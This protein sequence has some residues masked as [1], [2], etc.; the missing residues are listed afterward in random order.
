VI[1][2]ADGK[3]VQVWVVVVAALASALVAGTA[4]YFL[5]SAPVADMSARFAVEQSRVTSLTAQADLLTKLAADGAAEA[6]AAWAKVPATPVPDPASAG[7]STPTSKSFTTYAYVRK[8]TGPLSEVFTV[9][10]DPF[11]ILTDKAASD[12]AKAHGQTPPSNGILLVNES[13]KTTSYPLAD[14]AK[15]TAYTG[16]VEVMTPLPIQGGK[17]QQ[18]AADPTVIPDA[19]SDQWQITVK[20]GVI[21]TIKMIAIAG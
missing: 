2:M 17:L 10:I 3:R 20:N 14:T 4:V 19:S 16:G 5:A 13:T 11:E 1:D 18:W 9:Y 21:T 8:L 15:I 6:D 12:Y 7:S